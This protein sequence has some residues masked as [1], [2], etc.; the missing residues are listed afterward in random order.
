MLGI[1]SSPARFI[2]VDERRPDR[3]AGFRSGWLEWVGAEFSVQGLSQ[4]ITTFS[5]TRRIVPGS[6][7]AELS[8]HSQWLRVLSFRERNR[9][10]GR[11]VA[12]VQTHICGREERV[13]IFSG[14][15]LGRCWVEPA[16][17]LDRKLTLDHQ[18]SRLRLETAGQDRSIDRQMKLVAE[19]T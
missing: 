14:C 2:L 12:H 1:L 7:G 3:P 10:H 15:G 5:C 11:H 9:S 13:S 17:F 8:M 16:S 19:F 18:E 4:A 6:I